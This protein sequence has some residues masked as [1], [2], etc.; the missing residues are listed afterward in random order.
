MST[1]SAGACSGRLP[2]VLGELVRLYGYDPESK[3]LFYSSREL[4]PLEEQLYSINKT[5]KDKRLL[6]QGHGQHEAE[7]SPDFSLWV[8]YHTSTKEP[9]R[10]TLAEADSGR[11]DTKPGGQCDAQVQIGCLQ[12]KQKE[13]IGLPVSTGDTLLAYLMKPTEM[14]R[15][16][17]YPLLM[18][19]YGGPGVQR[20]SD[21]W[22]GSTQL[23]FHYLNQLG[24]VVACVD[25][26]GTGGRGAAFKKQTYG[27]LGEL[28]TADQLAAARQLAQLP[29][30]DPQRIGIVGLELRWLFGLLGTLHRS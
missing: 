28:E 14:K 27:R 2:K 24:Y 5:G 17:R 29:Y 15:K 1:I 11:I 13:L 7:F 9:L 21:A 4:S 18:Y 16:Q 30:V 23:W 20:V 26:R 25:G 22:D 10:M 8:D 12:P 3:R 6:S 19:V